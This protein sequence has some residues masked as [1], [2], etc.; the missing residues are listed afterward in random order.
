MILGGAYFVANL[1]R[2]NGFSR[3]FGGDPSDLLVTCDDIHLPYSSP[4][5][6]NTLYGQRLVAL[7]AINLISLV[8]DLIDVVRYALGNRYLFLQ[9]TQLVERR[10]LRKMGRDTR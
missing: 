6:T 10:L 3:F 9:P 1:A 7:F 4:V 5:N 2:I 8:T